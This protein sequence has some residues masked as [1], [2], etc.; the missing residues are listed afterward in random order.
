MEMKSISIV[1]SYFNLFQDQRP[2]SGCFL[3][4]C[5]KF[6]RPIECYQSQGYDLIMS[7]FNTFYFLWIGYPA[8]TSFDQ[9]CC[10][11]VVCCH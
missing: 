11:A 6:M 3:F 2:V 1:V 8:R 5:E 10:T 4:F 9:V 7:D